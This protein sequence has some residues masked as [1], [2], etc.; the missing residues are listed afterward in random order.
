MGAMTVTEL[1]SAGLAKAGVASSRSTVIKTEFLAYLRRVYA[2]W[3]WS[4]T[5]RRAEAVALDSGARSITFGNGSGIP[6]VKEIRDPLFIYTSDYK[7]AQNV[8][9]RTIIGGLPERDETVADPTK[10]TGTPQYVKCR[11]ASAASFQWTLV[12]DYVADKN[13][14]LAIDYHCIPDDPADGAAPLYP[15]DLTLIKMVEVLALHDRKAEN[16]MAERDILAAMIVNDRSV[17]GTSDGL[18]T[19][20]WGLDP[21]TFK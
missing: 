3:P 2:Q 8:R 20:A 10:S 4:F 21:N 18:N 16:Y 17:Y 15:D 14:L 7:T 12:F 13:Y 19:D 9:V 11:A 6:K 1:V 5:L